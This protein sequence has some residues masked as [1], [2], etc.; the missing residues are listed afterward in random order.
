M[1][2]EIAKP[3]EAEELVRILHDA[4]SENEKLG[5][6]ASASNVSVPEVVDWIQNM[7]VLSAKEVGTDKISGTVR[8]AYKEDWQCYVLGRLAVAAS[9]KGQG[10]GTRLM[11]AAE[12]ELLKMG[13]KKVLLT[14]AKRHPYLPEMY[15]RKGYR[16]VGERLLKHL[17]Y[18][19]YVMEKVL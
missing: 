9:A 14:V 12:K 17:P 18:D 11:E 15:Q 3:K 10:V 2:I 4:Y 1:K 5:L 16:I 8:L 19:E 13:E 6:P 7:M